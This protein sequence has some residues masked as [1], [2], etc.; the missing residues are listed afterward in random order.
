MR[1]IKLRHNQLQVVIY[2]RKAL[3]GPKWLK[4]KTIRD[5]TKI[6][7]RTVVQCL[8]A[9][10]QRNLVEKK[11]SPTGGFS[12]KLREVDNV[13]YVPY[14]KRGKG[15]KSVVIENVRPVDLLSALKIFAKG[16]KKPKFIETGT[17]KA[18]AQAI[19]GLYKHAVDTAYGAAANPPELKY[20]RDEL[21]E[22]AEQLEAHLKGIYAILDTDELWDFR[23]SA[24]FVLS[25][26]QGPEIQEYQA[27]SE[28]AIKENQ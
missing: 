28:A 12:W 5:Y 18:Y 1:E 23:R 9:L 11:P 19:G 14:P 2:L 8:N 21:S 6:D 22:Y 4:T 25:V 24:S 10:E 13:D 16:H 26:E 7:Y 15:P 27:L 17:Y 20:Y 3:G